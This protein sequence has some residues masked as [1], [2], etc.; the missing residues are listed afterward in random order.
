MGQPA[1]EEADVGGGDDEASCPG[2]G[3]EEPLFDSD[4]EE[5]SNLDWDQVERD[6]AEE[7]NQG[8]AEDPQAPAP[9]EAPQEERRRLRRR[10]RPAREQLHCPAP[11]PARM[12]HT[13][14]DEHSVHS[15]CRAWLH[16]SSHNAHS[17]PR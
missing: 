3:L 4:C 8:G 15:S 16:P 12:S 13:E 1:A 5:M 9:P 14:L 2:W 17:T 10:R 6:V 7:L 11:R